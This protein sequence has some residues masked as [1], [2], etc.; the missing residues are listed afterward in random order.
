MA[1]VQF[2]HH[3]GY[4]RTPGRG[5]EPHETIEGVT[6]EAGRVPGNAP[7]VRYPQEPRILY[8]ISPTKVGQMALQLSHM[9][10]D[11][12][13]RRSDATAWCLRQGS[14]PIR[15]QSQI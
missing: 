13:G 7:H 2:I 12:Q 3:G 1:A 14:S 10:R 8:G 15:Y 4:G 5:C 6:A 11:R 9:A